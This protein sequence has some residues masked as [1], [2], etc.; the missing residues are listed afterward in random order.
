LRLGA[1]LVRCSLPGLRR[2][3]EEVSAGEMTALR[4]V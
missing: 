1:D 2:Q 4:A 3:I